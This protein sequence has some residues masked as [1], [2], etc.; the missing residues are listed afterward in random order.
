MKVFSKNETYLTNHK[1]NKENIIKIIETVIPRAR[2]NS[3]NK[4]NL[5]KIFNGEN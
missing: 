5:Y 2:P 4:L 1:N 3:W